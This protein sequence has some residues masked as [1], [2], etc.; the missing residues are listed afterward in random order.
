MKKL[1]LLALAFFPFACSFPVA[2][3]NVGSLPPVFPDYPGVTVPC[4][5]APLNFCIKDSLASDYAVVMTAGGYEWK[6]RSRD[7]VFNIPDTEWRNLLSAGDSIRVSA[8]GRIGGSWNS[9]DPYSIYVSMDKVDPYLA[10]RLIP[11]GYEIWDEIGLYQRCL[12][13][14]EQ[15]PIIENS[16]T[17]GNCMNCHSFASRNPDRFLFHM[18]GPL[19]GTYRIDGRDV[20]K[21][22]TKTD[23]TISALVYPSW[24]ETGDY[25]AFSVNNISQL[26]HS[27]NRNRVE[28]FDTESD[29]VV[30]D[31][32]KHEIALS[33][34]TCTEDRFETFPTFS[35]DGDWLYF[36]SSPACL[37][38]PYQYKDLQYDI[39]RISFDRS[40]CSFGD[41][42]ETVYS[43]SDRGSASF[44]RVSPDGSKLIFTVQ[45]Y[46]NFSVWHKDA[47]LY[48]IDLSASSFT[49][50]P[51][52]GFNSGDSESYHSWS[53]NSRWVV[54][55]SR[56]DDGLY[57][58]PYIGHIDADGK[59]AKPFLLPQL[60]PD[61]YYT[62]LMVS[63]NIPEFVS[64]KIT[65]PEEKIVGIA[66]QGGTDVKVK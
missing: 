59:A 13:S 23:E 50:V 52:N 54:F 60:N 31:V 3:E 48:M 62:E 4:N 37:N 42:L 26:F 18:R 32:A 40:N 28:V 57:T 63:F 14:F 36:C 47:D 53:S 15:I 43:A 64:G 8:I 45:P 39:M 1:F 2:E 7:G 33:P 19:A 61:E 6:S 49:A 41:E 56:R 24:C 16:S 38:M 27:N 65:V 9:Y 22:N 34:L 17:E 55:S 66:R 20:E 35:P 12:E 11:P 30:Y 5:I 29:V 44:P 58:K 21:L 10:Y 25:V 51:L 46:G